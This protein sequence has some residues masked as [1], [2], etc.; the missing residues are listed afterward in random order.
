[1]GVVEW[2]IAAC[3]S[4]GCARVL[5]VGFDRWRPAR[6]MR[7]E[8]WRVRLVMNLNGLE[9]PAMMCLKSELRRVVPMLKR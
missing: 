7:T 9:A 3:A 4:F 5:R 2:A 1:M 6:G 8:L